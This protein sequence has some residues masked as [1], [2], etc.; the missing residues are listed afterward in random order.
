MK[1][2]IQYHHTDKSHIDF[3]LER[4]DDLQ[5]WRIEVEDYRRLSNGKAVSLTQNFPHR[6]MYLAYAGE[7][8]NNRGRLELLDSGEYFLLANDS[9]VKIKV[10]GNLFYG[11]IILSKI[12]DEQWIIKYNK[13]DK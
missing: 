9:E 12:S 3:F 8:S 13:E 1:F 6:K 10:D 2:S 4:N 11:L 7:I 5:A